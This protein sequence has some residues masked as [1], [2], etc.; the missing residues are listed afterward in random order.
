MKRFKLFLYRILGLEKYLRVISHIYISLI[1][2]GLFKKE[3]S[4][5]HFLKHLIQQGFTCVDIGANLGY[6][7]FFLSKLVGNNG[8]VYAVEPVPLFAKI[9]KSNVQ[10]THINNVTIYPF[11]LGNEEKETKMGMPIIVD[12]V[13]HGMT[14]IV[15]NSLESYERL[16]DVTMKIPDQLF[17]HIKHIDFIKIDVEGF[18]HL[19]LSN[20]IE[21]L[22][23]HSPIIQG[24]MSGNENRKKCFTLLN[25]LNYHPYLLENNKLEKTDFISA[26]LST[27]DIY[28]I[29]NIKS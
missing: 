22:K 29:R 6:Y 15:T 5:L 11:A 4:N 3:Y 13:H 18:E 28:F 2:L 24:E 8:N 27:Q 21:T 23:R 25:E 9:L 26:E 16:F 20:M 14:Q 7:S 1:R 19:V 10:R 17:Q 12:S